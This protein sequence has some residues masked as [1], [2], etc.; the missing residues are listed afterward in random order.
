VGTRRGELS[1]DDNNY[2]EEDNIIMARKCG[3]CECIAI[4]GRSTPSQSYSR[5][6]TDIR[7]VK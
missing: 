5:Y 2:D 1:N 4:L 3:N 7:I 6:V